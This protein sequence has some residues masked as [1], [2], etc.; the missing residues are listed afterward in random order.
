MSKSGFMFS[1]LE[2]R[3]L[4][5]TSSF[6]PQRAVVENMNCGVACGWECQKG[7]SLWRQESQITGFL[8]LNPEILRVMGSWVCCSTGLV[9]SS[10][11]FRKGKARSSFSLLFV[12]QDGIQ[13]LGVLTDFM[14]SLFPGCLETDDL[15]QIELGFFLLQL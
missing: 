6:A 12:L 9:N 1:F 11:D 2:D 4:G 3:S 10:S 7:A 15:E 8:L 13:C 5:E 14:G